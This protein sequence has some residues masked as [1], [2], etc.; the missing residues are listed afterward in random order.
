MSKSNDFEAAL[1]DLI[2][3]NVG[4]PNIGDAGG[5]RGSVAAGSLF[6]ALNT[7]DPGEVGTAIT[8]ETA[9]TGYSRVGVVRGGAG[10]VRTA[11][12]VSPVANAE[13]GECTALPGGPLTHFSVVST[14]AGAGI[15]LYSGTLTPN[16]AMTVNLI[17]R[18]RNT[19]TITED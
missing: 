11:N 4:L 19:S 7:A 2:F 16:I 12:S 8:A 9:Y 13:F 18:I 14:A 1:L 6:L 17:P 5:L 3:L 10:W 15:I